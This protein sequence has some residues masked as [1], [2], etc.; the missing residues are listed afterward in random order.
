MVGCLQHLSLTHLDLAFVVNQVCQFMHMPTTLH[1]QA[2]KCILCLMVCFLLAHHLLSWRLY[3]TLIGHDAQKIN[4]Q[5][6]LIMSFW[7]QI[8]FH[9]A[10]ENNQ[11]SLDRVLRQSITALRIQQNYCGFS[12]CFMILV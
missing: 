11:P 7:F 5:Q 3:Q 12:Y 10:L 2:V 8:E 1:W 4:T 6:E 9:R